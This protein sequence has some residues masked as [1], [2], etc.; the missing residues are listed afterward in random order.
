MKRF[1]LGITMFGTMFGSAALLGGCPV[2]SA[3]G[4]DF[5]VCNG[6]GCF[7]CP[8]SQYSNACVPWSCLTDTDCP[9]AYVCDVTTSACVSGCPACPA[10]MT[11][12]LSNGVPQC[13][14]LGAGPG[15]DSGTPLPDATMDAASEAGSVST[16]DAAP[17]SGDAGDAQADAQKS[18]AAEAGLDA[19][20][21]GGGCNS[22]SACAGVVGAKCVD[23]QCMQQ[24]ELCSD[25]T[26]CMVSDE[27]CV[28]G[29]CV[30]ACSASSPCPAG[31][32]CDFNRGVC[33]S[34][35]APCSNSASCTGGAVC[36][37]SHCVAPCGPADSGASCAG[38]QV[39]IN[40]GCIPDQEAQFTCAGDG[41]ACGSSG[42]ICVHGDC[43]SPCPGDGATCAGAEP[44]CKEVPGNRGT[45]AVCGTA[46][47]LGDQ[48]NPAAGVYCQNSQICIDGYCK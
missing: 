37:E 24:A 18:G 4:S 44:V 19:G 2:Y 27:R 46:T 48:C 10:G 42:G 1:L 47:N 8:V 45:Y 15:Y 3:R 17:G 26:Q 28:D 41:T 21:S 38:G 9:S 29:L 14:T 30:P 40:G 34:G 12:A 39:C 13:T 22:D 20:S 35:P 36:V 7:D 11:C 33:G 25:G 23:G 32:A 16:G 31:Y 5:Q 6:A 43:Y